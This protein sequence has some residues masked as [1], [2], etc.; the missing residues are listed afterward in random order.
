MQVGDL[1]KNIHGL[2][3]A[4]SGIIIEIGQV[5]ECKYRVYWFDG[6]DPAWMRED[7]LERL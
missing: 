4:E 1:V 7:W 6:F 3:P 2:Y 5:G